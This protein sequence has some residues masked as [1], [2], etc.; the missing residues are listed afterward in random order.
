MNPNTSDQA[1]HA[2]AIAGAP[3]IANWRLGSYGAVGIVLSMAALPIYVH[4][5]RF[6]AEAFGLTLATIGLVLLAVRVFDAFLDPMLGAWSDVH[7]RR[8]GKRSL[9]LLIGVPLMSVGFVMLYVPNIFGVNQPGAI[10]LAV[11]LMVVYS[12]Y[13]TAIVSYNAWGAEMSNVVSQ[14]TRI[15]AWREGLSVVGVFLAAALPAMYAKEQGLIKGYESFVWITIAMAALTLT[16]TFLF[17]PQSM[18]RP[19]QSHGI[20]AAFRLP[21][22]NADFRPL[23]AIFVLNGI[24]AAIP[25]TLFQFFIADV[26]Q[27]NDWEATFLISYFAAGVIGLPFWVALSNRIGQAYSWAISMLLAVIAFVWAVFVGVGD[28]N[29]F[30]IICLMSGLA[31]GADQTIPAALLAQVIDHDEANG[32]GRNEGAYFGLWALTTKLNLALA[33]GIGLPLVQWLGYTPGSAN[34]EDALK[35]LAIGY[36]VVPCVLKLAAFI[37]L[38]RSRFVARERRQSS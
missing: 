15:V 19:T 33:A 26:V 8:G 22:A 5:S 28:A 32:K 3:K 4:V 13:S 1:M 21:F 16:A 6:Y 2:I 24:A 37:V 23:F 12:G 31:F 34:S 9:F 25:A 20:F 29:A 38:W 14:R 27:K 18:S 35:A 10:W 17:A 11:S 30:L 36:A 7:C